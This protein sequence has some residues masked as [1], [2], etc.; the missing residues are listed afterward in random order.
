MS[1]KGWTSHSELLPSCA[2]LSSGVEGGEEVVRHLH[3]KIFDPA[4]SRFTT[5]ELF[6]GKESYSNI[7]GE[8][9]GSSIDRSS[10]LSLE[11]LSRRSGEIAGEKRE[12][13]SPLFARV[14]KIRGILIPD[15]D[16][17][18]FFVY[19]DPIEGS[20]QEHAI[21]RGSEDVTGKAKMRALRD[22]LLDTFQFSRIELTN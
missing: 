3:S 13:R 20:N 8:S 16:D 7:C 4:E 2:P 9:D 14:A 11:E 17:Q 22:R 18:A 12:P 10:N 19:D 5:S 15:T 21:I 6:Q 1:R